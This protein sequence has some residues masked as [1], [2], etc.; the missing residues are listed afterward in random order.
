MPQRYANYEADCSNCYKYIAQDD[1]IWFEPRTGNKLCT[2]CAAKKN[3]IC[4]NCNG[5]KKPQFDTCFD[6]GTTTQTSGTGRG[7]VRR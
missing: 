5:S 1:P 3:I 2:T 6:C 4:S 7:R